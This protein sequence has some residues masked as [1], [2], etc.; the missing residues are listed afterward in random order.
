M[1]TYGYA[2]V[3]SRD[4]NESLQVEALKSFGVASEKIFV[5]RQSGKDFNRPQYQKLLLK[6]QAEDTFVVKSIDRLGRDYAE[7]LEQWRVITKEK[8]AAIVVLD[9]PLLDTRN[10]KDFLGSLIADLALQ[11]MS[12][13]AQIERDFIRQR[14]AEGIAS[15]KARGVKFGRPPLKRPENYSAVSEEWRLGKISARKAGKLLGVTSQTFLRWIRSD[16]TQS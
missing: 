4:Q 6:L 1:S 5:D 10:K 2:R 11:I 3:S 13:F 16:E 9:M 14:Q 12:A 7:I 8:N 15:A